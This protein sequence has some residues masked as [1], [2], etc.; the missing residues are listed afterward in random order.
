MKNKIELGIFVLLISIILIGAI[1]F[2]T[3]V[4]INSG[5]TN[6]I[7]TE[8]LVCLWNTTADMTEMNVTWLKNG[9]HFMNLTDINSTNSTIPYLNTSKGQTWI[10]NVTITNGTILTSSSDSITIENAA[11]NTPTVYNASNGAIILNGT[12]L[13]EDISYI[14]IF[15]STDPDNDIL[16]YVLSSSI[17]TE[18]NSSESRINCTPTSSNLGAGNTAGTHS[19]QFIASD[20]SKLSGNIVE[21]VIQPYNDEPY[22]SPVL[23]N[24]TVYTNATLNYSITALDEEGDYPLNFSLVS[25]PIGCL[26]IT[27]TSNTTAEIF[28]DPSINNV[29]N[30]TVIVNISDN[31]VDLS[32]KRTVLSNFTLQILRANTAPVITNWTY[33]SGTQNE[34]YIITVNAT[35][36]DNNSLTLTTSTG[37]CS[38]ANPWPAITVMNLTTNGTST[39]GQGTIN[40]TLNNSH[41]VCNN[42]TL[43]VTDGLQ[44]YDSE[45]ILLNLTNVNDPPTIINTSTNLNSPLNN[46]NINNLIAYENA[47]FIYQINATDMDNLTYEGDNITYYS[48]TTFINNSLNINSG[49]ISFTPNST[50]AGNNWSIMIFV[51]DSH[52]NITNK[53][54]SLEILGNSPPTFNG[55]Q[56]FTLYCSEYDANYY[57]QSCY[58][59]FS[60]N[61]SDTDP[62]DNITFYDNSSFFVINET[63]GIINFTP[64]WTQIGNWSVQINITDA[65][66]ANNQT[67]LYL[68]I[69]NTNNG[70]TIQPIELPT[71]LVTGHPTIA[72]VDVT[73]DDFNNDNSTENI[74][75]NYTNNLGGTNISFINLTR[76]NNSRQILWLDL[77]SAEPGNYSINI[78]VFDTSNLTDVETVTFWV[79]N[80]TAPPDITQVIPF[81]TP[82]SNFTNFT[83]TNNDFSNSITN[84]N[85][86]ENNTYL[87]N[88]TT[89]DD[90]G[91]ENL[92]FYWFYDG[93]KI[94]NNTYLIE[95]N[96]TLNYSFDFFSSGNHNITLVASDEKLENT[97]FTWNITTADV[98]RPPILFA[99]FSDLTINSTTQINTFLF[100][101]GDNSEG[102]YDPDD[103]NNSNEEIDCSTELSTLTYNYSGCAGIATITYIT[104][105]DGH[106]VNIVGREVDSCYVNFTATDGD[107]TVTSNNILINI[108]DTA[109][110]R[111][112]VTYSTGSSQRVLTQ[113]ITVPVP[114]E[115]QKP[116][117][118]DVVLPELV[119]ILNN[120]S[121]SIPVKLRNNW[122]TSL[123]GTRM[124]ARVNASGVEVSFTR[125]YFYEILSGET[126]ETTMT[127]SNYRTG[128]N[129]ELLVYAN[130]SE[131]EFTD[132][133][134]ILINSLEQSSKGQEVETKVT[135]AQDLLSQNPEC[136]ELNE[137]LDQATVK[138]RQGEYGETLKAVDAVINGCKYLMSQSQ[139]SKESPKKF[140]EVVFQLKG[141]YFSYGLIG[142]GAILIIVLGTFIFRKTKPKI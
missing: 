111:Q 19:A 135:F 98:N 74:T 55:A 81:G 73:D 102:F 140:Q 62:G 92:S 113:T 101:C 45:T 142:L 24:K 87:F 9:I 18:L 70:P 95:S 29:G 88:H 138:F 66:G 54:M 56:N 5:A 13:T 115:V 110:S 22:F 51:K 3:S 7:T 46:V 104:S 84:I 68:I 67:T 93:T 2:N 35:D 129:F 41:I 134:M 12:N 60:L 112:V 91:A 83:W 25:T 23:I 85:L 16:T 31:P 116:V 53:T 109:A 6:A 132:N 126:V 141:E 72:Y 120:D 1:S 32:E 48:N 57:N 77:D 139:K 43:T 107:L 40:I 106:G 8:N 78:T 15:N 47:P 52:N 11:P 36:I 108:T 89:T 117:P 38:L 17:C 58:F 114:E 10:C 14:L 20:G 124:S 128:E 37:S 127:V 50:L 80:Q 26:N 27:Q 97:S 4:S 136:Q 33:T 100:R 63:T 44:G 76:F 61:T 133:A 94:T 21:F 137:Y 118:L 75:F 96:H 34:N 39:F 99:N 65:R 103:D 119:T 69:N 79:Y 122:N 105:D 131:P 82:K 49:L 42:L 86:T 123:F 59:N 30:W 90:E 125:D 121:L 64:N 71:P 130:V 28:C